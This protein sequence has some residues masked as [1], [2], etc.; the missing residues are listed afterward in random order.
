MIMI[1]IMICSD[2][3]VTMKI[4]ITLIIPIVIIIVMLTT[5]MIIRI[6]MIE[7]RIIMIVRIIMMI[8]IFKNDNLLSFIISSVIIYNL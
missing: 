7:I 1:T 6:M 8:M 5:I 2:D 3:H 4:M